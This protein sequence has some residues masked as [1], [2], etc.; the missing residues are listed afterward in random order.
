MYTTLKLFIGCLPFSISYRHKSISME[1]GTILSFSSTSL[2]S[3]ALRTYKNQ[4]NQDLLTPI[5][6]HVITNR[7]SVNML[8]SNLS[9]LNLSNIFCLCL[10]H[11]VSK[12]NVEGREGCS[13]DSVI[14][15]RPCAAF[16]IAAELLVA[17]LSSCSRDISGD[18]NWGYFL[19]SFFVEVTFNE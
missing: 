11:E 4:C 9:Y 5:F 13:E 16:I 18:C 14:V 7:I 1:C 15:E 19:C 8:N 3:V 12:Q 17:S 10:S 2:G 6:R